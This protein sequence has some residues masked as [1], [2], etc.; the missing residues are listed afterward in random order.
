MLVAL[1]VFVVAT[2]GIVGTYYAVTVLPG[3]LKQRQVDRRLRQLSQ[4]FTSAQTDGA[5]VVLRPEERTLLSRIA[6]A[7]PGGKSLELLIEQSGVRT[8]IA[9][10][11]FFSCA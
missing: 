5:S 9:A 11:V 2:A 7:V 6:A 4:P 8:S 10:V 1:F 3:F